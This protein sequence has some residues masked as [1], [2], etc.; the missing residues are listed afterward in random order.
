MEKNPQF[1]TDAEGHRTA[2][3]LPIEDYEEMMED[4]EIGRAARESKGEPRRPFD[5]VVKELRAAGEIDFWRQQYLA[6]RARAETPRPA[7]EEPHCVSHLGA[8][9][10]PSLSWMPPESSSPLILG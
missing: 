4:S 2:V 1:V 8:Q 6:G 5:D 7:R 3:I 10:R 9:L